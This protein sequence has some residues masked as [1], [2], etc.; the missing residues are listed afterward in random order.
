MA[1]LG[2]IARR[3]FITGAVALAGGFAVGYYYYKKEVPNPLLKDLAEGEST[4]NPFVKI[5]GK[6][7]ITVI[8]PR[9][10]MGQGVNKH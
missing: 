4:F 1:S 10:E 6:G 2:K 9:A 3:T 8:A 7:K 5:D